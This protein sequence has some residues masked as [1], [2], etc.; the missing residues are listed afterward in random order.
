MVCFGPI[1][2]FLL[3]SLLNLYSDYNGAR[4][5]GM[6]ALLL[7]RSDEEASTAVAEDARR[8]GQVV[9]DMNEVV[10]WVRARNCI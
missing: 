9:K 10:Q 4:K 1:F 7:R 3:S 2:S 5:A 8:A 6:N